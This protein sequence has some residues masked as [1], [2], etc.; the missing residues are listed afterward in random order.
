MGGAPGQLQE[1]HIRLAQDV[2]RG[3]NKKVVTVAVFFDTNLKLPTQ[4]FLNR[5]KIAVRVGK[6]GRWEKPH[7]SG[8]PQGSALGP[9]LFSMY[10][11]GIYYSHP[12]EGHVSQFADDLCCF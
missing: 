11:C 3:F 8:S 9:L 7:H 2:Q 1:E 4:I 12:R 5:R 10:I 6:G